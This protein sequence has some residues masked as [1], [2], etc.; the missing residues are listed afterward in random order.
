MA[1]AC[2][3]GHTSDCD[4]PHRI[5]RLEVPV[6]LDQ[7]FKFVDRVIRGMFPSEIASMLSNFSA[8]ILPFG[9]F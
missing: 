6:L 2:D 5:D 4:G 1:A 8:K 9:G 3:T 7:A